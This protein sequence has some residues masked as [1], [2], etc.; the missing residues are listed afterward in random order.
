MDK[1]TNK[2]TITLSKILYAN[3]ENSRRMHAQLFNYTITCTRI[4]SSV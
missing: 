2:Q 3:I 4:L 1:Q